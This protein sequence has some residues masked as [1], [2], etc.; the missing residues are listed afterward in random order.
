MTDVTITSTTQT[1]ANNSTEN[2][3]AQTFIPLN[4]SVLVVE[5]ETYTVED[6][7]TDFRRRVDVRENGVL[8]VSGT[9]NTVN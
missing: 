9:I 6:G 2:A 4:E 7:T 3:S 8:N 1:V 5:N